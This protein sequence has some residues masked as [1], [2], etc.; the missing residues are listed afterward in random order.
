M[1]RSSRPLESVVLGL[2]FGLSGCKRVDH[3]TNI[4]AVDPA[5][6]YPAGFGGVAVEAIEDDGTQ[7]DE[8]IDPRHVETLADVEGAF[9]LLAKHNLTVALA[10]QVHKL[11]LPEA[12]DA[13]FTT[14]ERAHRHGIEVRPWLVL[15]FA[16][17]YFPSA[18]NADAFA[19]HARDLLRQWQ[20]R[21]LKPT[22]LLV[23]MEPS[24]ELQEAL[25]SM[26][27]A[28]ALP[29]DHID[30][31]RFAQATRTYAELVDELHGQGWKAQLSAIATV[32]ADY[33]D[34]DDD[35]RQY[36]G[37][38]VEGVSWD[39]LDFQVYR[40]AFAAL[41]PGLGPHFVYSYVQEALA[42][43]PEQDLGFTLGVTH[44]GPILQDGK[45]LENG[46]E[47]RKDVEAA[48][49]AGADPSR[50]SVYNL[51]GILLGPPRCEKVLPCAS[52]D[53]VYGPDDPASWL[54]PPADHI[55]IPEVSAATGILSAMFDGMDRA[56]DLAP[57]TEHD[58]G[59]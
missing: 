39:Q 18:L 25:S 9:P 40:S 23:D 30:Q 57:A 12:M 49:A 36:F 44:P 24:R 27:I 28:E 8:H 46:A 10:I 22:T 55:G 32:I 3:P 14:I 48:L 15:S 54:E 33:R 41:A 20:A 47:L 37:V 56:L 35:L 45:T 2:L 13:V 26:N 38:I 34:D 1:K 6:D 58:A 59:E 43:F 19:V 7:G 4:N 21:G 29:R 31:E 11:A 50:L 42:R 51:K 52:E 53:Y 5:H 16:D 17:G